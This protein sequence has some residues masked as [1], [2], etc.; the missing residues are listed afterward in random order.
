MKRRPQQP[1]AQNAP[2]MLEVT[3][4]RLL[5]GGV[6]LAHADGRTV[7]VSD[8]A[9][10]DRLRVRVVGRKGQTLFA[11]IAEILTPGPQRIAPPCVYVGRCGGCDFQHL[12]Y[13]AQLTAKLSI[14]EDCLRR[15]AQTA[16]P[17]DFSII[18][19]PRPFGYRTRAE[20]QYEMATGRVGY[21]ARGS[22]RV[23]DV[24]KC[25]VLDAPLQT[26]L[27]QARRAS[28]DITRF[29]RDLQLHALA[30]AD[31]VAD[32]F[33]GPSETTIRIGP[34]TYLGAAAGFFQSS[35]DLLPQML[36]IALKDA[37]HPN[38]N[39]SHLPSNAQPFTA[40]DLYCGVGLFTV[41][42]SER[43]G[44]VIAVENNAAAVALA[45][46][47]LLAHNPDAKAR[48]V[49]A[50]VGEWLAENA[51]TLQQAN[52]VLLDPPRTGVENGVI[53]NLIQLA[54]AN[55]S[56]V[57]CDPATLAR[58]LKQF[59]SN[60]YQL[61]SVTACDLFPQTHHIETVARLHN[62]IVRS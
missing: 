3:I 26:K 32:T 58:D 25:L 41:P 30:G 59:L 49:C 55:I 56:Y 38:I 12:T 40:L 13:E 60:G 37:P 11:E 42:L 20:W 29:D 36:A 31:E 43:F 33:G 47:N 9:P 21:F 4:E 27:T 48:V 19:A 62:Q 54:P 18:P 8:A 46:R 34:Y 24:E 16:P 28:I 5:P 53:E 6:G 2:E 52:F 10:Q 1:R 61:T 14:V 23:C 35:Q 50:N 22:H 57:S 39:I 15:I 7:L 44:R 45:H 17:A 51:P